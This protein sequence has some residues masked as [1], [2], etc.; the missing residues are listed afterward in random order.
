MF[1]NI[2]IS[3]SFNMNYKIENNCD[4]LRWKKQVKKSQ[5]ITKIFY[6]MI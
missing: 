5:R 6:T 1:Q 2:N 3:E 4:W